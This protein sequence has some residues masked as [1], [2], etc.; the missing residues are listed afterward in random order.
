MTHALV[1]LDCLDFSSHVDRAVR[2]CSSK[3]VFPVWPVVSGSDGRVLEVVG[4][5]CLNV[6]I[7]SCPC[8]GLENTKTNGIQLI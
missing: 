8:C 1:K 7:C 5:S 4:L 6:L 3:V 2:C